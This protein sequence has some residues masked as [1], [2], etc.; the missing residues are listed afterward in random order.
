LDTYGQTA[1]F[2]AAL[3]GRVEVL[4]LL[5]KSGSEIDL[6]DH[7]G[8]TPIFYSLKSASLETLKWFINKHVD[9]NKMNTAGK[10]LI[11]KAA[12]KDCKI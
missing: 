6:V 2:Y 4:D 5:S 10:K 1:L 7:N 12:A 8:E 3:K 11:Q 9:L